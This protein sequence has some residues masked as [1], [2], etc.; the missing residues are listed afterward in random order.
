M[1]HKHV[2]FVSCSYRIRESY[3]KLSALHLVKVMLSYFVL[4]YGKH[5][6]YCDMSW[7]LLC[8]VFRL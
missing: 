3:K 1:G 4:L 5:G 7:F 2:D 6:D 8:N